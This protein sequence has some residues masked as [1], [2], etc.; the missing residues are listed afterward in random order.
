MTPEMQTLT[1]VIKLDLECDTDLTQHH[2]RNLGHLAKIN[3][4]KDIR[5]FLD[6]YKENKCANII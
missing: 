2:R 5:K 3:L 1:K 4:A 6:L